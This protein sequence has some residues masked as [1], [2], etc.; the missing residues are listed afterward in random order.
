MRVL[1][2]VLALILISDQH[3]AM[4]HKPTMSD[5]TAVDAAHAISFEDIQ[6]SRVVY[7]EVTAR[8]PQ[9]WI[10]FEVDRPQDLFLQIGVPYLERLKAYRP[11]LLLLGPG[12]PPVDVSVEYPSGIGGIVL[13]TRDVDRPEEFYEP[14]TGTRS[15]ILGEEDVR[16]P[17]AGRYYVVAFDPAGEPGKL[18][19]AT[20]RQEVWGAGD[21]LS[22]PKIISDV[23]RFHEAPRRFA[24]DREGPDD[25]VIF[26]FGSG[27]RRGDWLSVND[28]VMGGVS[29]GTFSFGEDGVMEFRGELSLENNGGFASIRSQAESYDLSGFDG[30]LL[31]VR[32]DGHLYSCNIRTDPNLEWSSYQA[33]FQTTDGKWEEIPLRFRDFAATSF[34]TAL[35]D[36]PALDMSSIRSI[37]FSIAEKQAGPFAMDLRRVDAV[38]AFDGVDVDTE[39][40]QAGCATCMFSMEGIGGCVLAVKIDGHPY[41]VQ[42]S[43]ID[44]HGD[45][46]APD[47]LCNSVRQARVRGVITGDRLVV[48]ELVLLP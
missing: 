7:H 21:L 9:V 14:F 1:V 26:E 46:H 29:K 20:G 48:D 35:P 39:S 2:L 16:L 31:R 42:G 34:G 28:D 41:L 37:G 43:D 36:A 38:A 15:W 27:E 24:V 25:R 6:I 10:T 40:A 8:S 18:W 44:A 32:G 12:L 30:L 3:P 13:A 23:R 5:G 4:A 47:G 11:T 33:P 17:Q 22:M 45:A 19:A